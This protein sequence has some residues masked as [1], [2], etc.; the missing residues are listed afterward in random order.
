MT[1]AQ[2]DREDIKE[3]RCRVI[4]FAIVMLIALLLSWLWSVIQT[5]DEDRVHNAMWTTYSVGNVDT[6]K[7][8][9]VRPS[10]TTP[11]ALCG[12]INY[13]QSDNKGWS[14]YSDFYLLDD[15]MYIAPAG[16]RYTT[17]FTA[18]CLAPPP[19][20]GTA[21]PKESQQ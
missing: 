2:E 13:E 3:V 5:T 17:Q 18:L 21:D 16:G 19:A 11:G 7:L 12:R 14:G 10:P 6:Y 8:A 9:Q 1:T 15:V 20:T 4:T